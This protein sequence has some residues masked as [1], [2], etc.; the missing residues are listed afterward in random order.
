MTVDEKLYTNFP[1][2]IVMYSAS[3]CPD[4]KRSKKLLD[5]NKIE[6]ALVDLGKDNQAFLFVEKLTRRVK[7][8]TIIFPDGTIMIEPSDM[9]LKRKLGL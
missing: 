3:W 9:Q 6:Y 5:D 4:C 1:E 7:I 2:K 8:P